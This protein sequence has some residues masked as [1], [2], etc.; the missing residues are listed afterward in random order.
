MPGVTGKNVFVS[1]EGV[2]YLL[3]KYLT[4]ADREELRSYNS[5]YTQEKFREKLISKLE[6]GSGSKNWIPSN[7]E[8]EL[9]ENAGAIIGT[10]RRRDRL[11]NGKEVDVYGTPNGEEVYEDDKGR[12][13]SHKSGRF[14]GKKAFDD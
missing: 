8:D 13:R 14:R 6:R 4:N 5:H 7:Y 12:I 3:D 1:I 11:K 10:N 9:V 2:E